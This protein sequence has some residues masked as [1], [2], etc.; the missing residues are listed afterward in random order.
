MEQQ[1]YYDVA[2]YCRLSRDD[3]M[4]GESSSI[5]TQKAMLSK[6]VQD[7]NWRIVDYY[8]DDGI[9]GT[10]YERPDFKRMIRDIEEGKI[11]LVITKDLSRLGRDYIQTG[12][13]TEIYFSEKNVRYIALN[14]GIDTIN[15]DNDIAPFKNILNE[16]YA[17]DIS[18]KV[19]SAYKIKAAR[20]DHHGA[21]APF[22]YKKH[23]EIKGKILIDDDSAEVV[24]LIFNLA[25]QG[26]GASRIRTELTKRKI[27]T[28][29]AYLNKL[30]PKYY[31]KEFM[32]AKPEKYYSWSMNAVQRI[33]QN[34]IYIGNVTHYKEISVSYKSKRRQPQTK[35]K[36]VTVEGSHEPLIDKE[37]WDIVQD[38]A[39]R[40]VNFGASHEPNIFARIARCVDCGWS[41]GLTPKQIDFKTK[42]RTERRYLQC[43]T[44]RVYGKTRCTLHNTNYQKLCEI[45]LEDIKAFSKLALENSDELLLRLT[46]SSDKKKL[47]ELEQTKKEL[48]KTKLRLN[49]LE[50]LLQRLFEQNVSGKMSDYNYSVMFKK[51][52]EEQETQRLNEK[53]LK[54][55]IEANSQSFDNVAKWIDL[56]KQYGNIQELDATIVNELI[57]KILIHEAKKENGKRTQKIEIYY[58]FIGK[59]SD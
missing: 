24:R 11:N 48:A 22:G 45:V 58:R 44:N 10:T 41:M 16:M 17:K 7:Q 34:E 9:S 55:R 42:K 35:D 39:G 29:S 50:L 43:S 8:V 5:L 52:Q 21:Y 59:A 47:K 14:D 23:P 30:N 3:D 57:E 15:S 53:E 13:Y 1:I 4:H 46:E 54:K 51:Y 32:N 31:A 12:Y 28:P 37:T 26:Y 6:Y 27:L 33:L 56:I 2:I 36:W 18:R 38:K 40:R 19:K 49:D 20:G 25:S